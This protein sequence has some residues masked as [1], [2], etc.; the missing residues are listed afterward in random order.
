MKGI[1]VDP[2]ALALRPSHKRSALNPHCFHFGASS[3]LLT[4]DNEAWNVLRRMCVKPSEAT[5]TLHAANVPWACYALMA[6]MTL[7]YIASF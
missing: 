2:S 7:T 3:F 1:S 6:I 4:S 5:V